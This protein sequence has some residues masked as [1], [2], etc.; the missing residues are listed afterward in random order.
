MTTPLRFRKGVVEKLSRLPKLAF[1]VSPDKKV[2]FIFPTASS[3]T[4]RF[5]VLG[6]S[7]VA[8]W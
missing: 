2:F 6:L 4:N 5:C 1:R 8:S 7:D 3:F